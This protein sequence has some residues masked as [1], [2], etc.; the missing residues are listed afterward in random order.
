MPAFDGVKCKINQNIFEVVLLLRQKSEKT[1]KFP[2]VS[3]P[4]TVVLSLM[5]VLWTEDDIDIVDHRNQKPII[6][7]WSK[8]GQL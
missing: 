2:I 1:L 5:L 6:I 3:N 4:I 7:V 8:S